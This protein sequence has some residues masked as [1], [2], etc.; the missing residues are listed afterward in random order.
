MRVV[1][2]NDRHDRSSFS[3][4]V[5]AL[6]RYFR[7]QARQDQRRRLGAVFVLVDEASSVVAGFYTLSACQVDPQ[8]LPS[9][10]ARRLPRRPA[11][12]TLLGRLAVDRRYR[13]QGIG[14]ALLSDALSRAL[15]ASASVGSMAVI[16]DAKDDAARAFYEH[17]GFQSLEDD[18]YRLFLPMATIERGSRPA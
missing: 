15:L 5:E 1:P 11:P 8:S 12:A 4:G 3:C 9:D 2:L 14:S 18:R 17:F 10:L 13:N 7:E 6:D 16:V